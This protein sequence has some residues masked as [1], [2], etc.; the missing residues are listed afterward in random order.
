MR[1]LITALAAIMMLISCASHRNDSDTSATG[2]HAETSAVIGMSPLTGGK[3]SAYPHARIYRTTAPSD[4]L[5]PITLSPDGATV[6]S[7][8]APG[9]LSSVPARLTGGWMLDSRGITPQ[10]AFTGFTYREYKAL[11]AAPSPARLLSSVEPGV[12]VSE[13]VE[14]PF[15]IGQATPAMADSLIR[16]GLPGCKTIFKL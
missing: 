3:A 4:S 6:I 5:V 12:K 7:Y 16:A 15:R 9:D 1:S 10:S 11:P 8:P 14:L 13:I 2:R